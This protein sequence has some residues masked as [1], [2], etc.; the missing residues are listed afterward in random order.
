MSKYTTEVRYIC[1]TLYGNKD[2]SGYADLNKILKDSAPKI[3]D[4]TFPIFDE[5][6]RTSLEIKILKHYYTREIGFETVGLWK[7]WL[8]KRMNEIMPYYNQLY[9]SELLEFNPFYDVDMTTDSNRKIDHDENS[10]ASNTQNNSNKRTD[11]NENAETHEDN[12]NSNSNSTDYQ[13]FSDTPQNQLNGVDNENYL[14]TA[15]KT[16]N[17]SSDKND[18]KGNSTST[19]NSATDITGTI[20]TDGSATRKYDN[21]DDYLEHVKGKSGNKSYSEL[22]TQYRQTFMNIDMLVIND[23]SDLFMNIW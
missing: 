21:V 7:M 13:L 3:F 1:E 16:T 5:A 15:T 4:F 22:L 8:D 14:T 23:L 20:I 12:S 18:S 2:S 17:E 11:V 6:Y 9:K 19:S 10:T